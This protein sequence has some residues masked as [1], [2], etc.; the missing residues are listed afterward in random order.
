M[1]AGV[2]PSCHRFRLLRVRDDVELPD[3]SQ[4]GL[5][6]IRVP[7]QFARSDLR[8]AAKRRIIRS[9]CCAKARAP[10]HYVGEPNG[11]LMAD[12]VDYFCAEGRDR[13]ADRRLQ[14][15]PLVHEADDVGGS[16]CVKTYQVADRRNAEL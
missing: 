11:H 3:G 9:A 13:R 1:V 14:V 16:F 15:G 2:A 8:A 12:H 7:L 4:F 10:D 6:A 5:S